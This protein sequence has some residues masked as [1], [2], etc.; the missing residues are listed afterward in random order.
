MI[1]EGKYKIIYEEG[2]KILTLKQMPQRLPT[3]CV[4]IKASNTFEI[5]LNKIQ[6]VIYTLYQANEIFK[7]LYNNII[8]STQL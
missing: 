7:K 1:S 6:Q 2:I 5:L 4:Q 8:N 3:A